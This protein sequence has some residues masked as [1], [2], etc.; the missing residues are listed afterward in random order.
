MSKAVDFIAILKY[1]TREE[2]GRETPAFTGYRP[3]VKFDF[4]EKQTSGEQT[5]MDKKTVY[6]GD[7][8]TAEIR[9]LSPDFF[10]NKLCV[11]MN[12]DF[13]EGNRI[14]GNG[15]IVTILNQHLEQI[16]L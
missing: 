7:S 16:V 3:Q 14:I 2:G 11:G 13:R 1:K 10:Q 6:P 15:K 8:V 5:F 12:F 9:L 4:S